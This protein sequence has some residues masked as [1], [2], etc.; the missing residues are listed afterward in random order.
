MKGMLQVFGMVA[1]MAIIVVTQ[2]GCLVAAAAGAAGGTVAYMKGDVEAVVDGNVDQT[3]NATKAAMDE[4]KLPLLATW[5]NAMEAHIEARVGTDNKATVNINGQSE[6]ISKVS[7]RVGT[8]GD[9][10]L[11]QAILEKIKANLSK[12]TTK[13]AMAEEGNRAESARESSSYFEIVNSM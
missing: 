12:A 11:S 1:V 9:Q 4:L 3:F 5:S 10:G 2:S 6:R 13:T 7:I 8:F